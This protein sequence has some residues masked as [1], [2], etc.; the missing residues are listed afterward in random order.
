MGL[1]LREK[2]QVDLRRLELS[3]HRVEVQ[4][5]KRSSLQREGFHATERVE[6]RLQSE[7]LGYGWV[8]WGFVS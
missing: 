3:L 2:E 4:F 5:A 7:A 1:S 8:W 6:Y